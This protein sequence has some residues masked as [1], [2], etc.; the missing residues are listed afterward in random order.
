MK[1]ILYILCIGLIT[2]SCNNDESSQNPDPGTLNLTFTN[3]I[4]GVAVQMGDTEYEN[5]SGERFVI[6]DLKYILSNVVL[7]RE[8]GTTFTYPVAD[9]YFVIDEADAGSKSI[10]LTDIDAGDYV[11]IRFGFGVDPSKYPIES[12]TLNFV[13]RAE[14]AGMLWSWSAGYKFILFEGTYKAA[15]SDVSEPFLYHV[16]SHGATLDNYKEIT[17]PMTTV[18]ING[19]IQASRALQFNV[20]DIFDSTHTLSIDNKNE[21]MVDPVNA[22]LIAENISTAFSVNQ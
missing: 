12:G 6:N 1:R 2:L 8:D 22:P 10:A 5:Q 18:N 15:G 7:V 17:L 20:A 19:Q 11:A 9:S 16:G 3:V 14:E 21:I 4:S 13:P